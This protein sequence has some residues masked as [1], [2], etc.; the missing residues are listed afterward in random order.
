MDFHLAT[1]YGDV[2][3][4]SYE[5]GRIVDTPPAPPAAGA[6]DQHLPQDQ[7]QETFTAS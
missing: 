5:D 4:F 6:P 1:P 3:L 2:Y 7:L